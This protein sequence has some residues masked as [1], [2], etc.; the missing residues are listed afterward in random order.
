MWKGIRGRF[1]PWWTC[2]GSKGRFGALCALSRRVGPAGLEE[3]RGVCAVQSVDA[4]DDGGAAA[5]GHRSMAWET[6][7][8]EV[9]MR[10]WYEGEGEE[11]RY[12]YRV[13]GTEKRGFESFEAA[14]DDAFREHCGIVEVRWM[15]EPMT[16]A[17]LAVKGVRREWDGVLAKWEE[18]E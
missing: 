17:Q 4:G 13:F 1:S 15:D 3:E 10:I 9:L 16:D 7:D 6:C 11:T 5:V 12:A 8:G 14:L 2:G 18:V